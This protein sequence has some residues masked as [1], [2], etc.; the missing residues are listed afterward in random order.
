MRLSVIIP[1]LNEEARIGRLLDEMSSQ[2]LQPAEIIV[3]DGQSKDK[4]RQVA[5]GYK[6][7][8]VLRHD[9]HVAGQRNYGASRAACDWLCFMDADSSV[10]EHFIKESLDE[11]SARSLSVACPMYYPPANANRLVHGFFSVL[12]W[13]FRRAEKHSPAG[14][15]NCI[16]ISRPLFDYI[17]GFPNVSAFED[18]ELINKAGKV[19][20]F[21]ILKTKLTV[22]DRRFKRRGTLRTIGLYSILG[23]LFAF[24]LYRL[25][26]KV[27]YKF[28]NYE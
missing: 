2:T 3:V 19:G 10:D 15:G 27:P 17:G 4:T 1:T 23:I 11:I 6:N 12:R 26:H 16:F 20:Q 14:G 18:A 13:F 28:G 25:A 22:S 9:P 21:G 7:V 24:S 8:R 5:G